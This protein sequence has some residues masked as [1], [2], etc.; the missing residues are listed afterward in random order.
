MN[1][2]LAFTIR[3]YFDKHLTSLKF[4]K[5]IHFLIRMYLF[6]GETFYYESLV[7]LQGEYIGITKEE[8]EKIIKES[9]TSVIPFSKEYSRRNEFLTKYP[10]IRIYETIL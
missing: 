9:L 3:N 5:Q 7:K 2:N 1:D 10:E 8:Q 6:T 4:N